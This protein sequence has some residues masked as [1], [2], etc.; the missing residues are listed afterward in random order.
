MVKSVVKPVELYCKNQLSL[1]QTGAA[2][3]ECV[4]S[5]FQDSENL[6]QIYDKNISIKSLNNFPQQDQ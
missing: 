5:N 6:W 1:S 4:A 3:K 2:V